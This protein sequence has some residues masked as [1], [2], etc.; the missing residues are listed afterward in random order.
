MTAEE[1][2]RLAC[3]AYQFNDIIR[4]LKTGR[5]HYRETARG[6]WMYRVDGTSLY[7]L[8]VAGPGAVKECVEAVKEFTVSRVYFITRKKGIV[9]L[10]KKYGYQLTGYMVERTQV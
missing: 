4:A 10:A 3:P 6:G 2:A 1:C 9:R 8:A 7:V 5:I